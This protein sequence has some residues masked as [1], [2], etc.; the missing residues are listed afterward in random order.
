MDCCRNVLLSMFVLALSGCSAVPTPW[1]GALGG[2]ALGAGTGAAIGALIANGDIAASAALG[3]AI[4]VPV[5]LGAA[6]IYASQVQS[7]AVE[8]RGEE[9]RANQAEI[10][11]TQQEIETLRQELRADA[12]GEP[13]PH[14]Y[15]GHLYTGR[16]LGNPFR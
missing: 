2:G 5:G 13:D 11:R 3:G 9:I 14:L 10:F 8:D 1:E 6:M 7:A 16:T 4:G 12:P 15:G